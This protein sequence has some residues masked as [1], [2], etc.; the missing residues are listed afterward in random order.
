M[1]AFDWSPAESGIKWQ[2]FADGSR[3]T[4]PSNPDLPVDPYAEMYGPAGSMIGEMGMNFAK[5]AGAP[6][7]SH[8][9]E[10]T[11]QSVYKVNDWANNMFQ[12]PMGDNRVLERNLGEL[13]AQQD[14]LDKQ[15]ELELAKADEIKRIAAEQ[16]ATDAAAAETSTVFK[17]AVDMENISDAS[18][19]LSIPVE[20]NVLSERILAAGAPAVDLK[21][22]QQLPMATWFMPQD[23]K[24]KYYD[25]K[26]YKSW[27]N[28][29]TGSPWGF[30]A[31]F[32]PNGVVNYNLVEAFEKDPYGYW[33]TN[34]KGNMPSREE[35]V[36]IMKQQQGDTMGVRDLSQGGDN[37]L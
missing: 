33:E 22:L 15:A 1:A 23:T 25:M 36:E 2:G 20:L 17:G 29:R 28:D 30:K 27:F 13:H 8:I 24:A 3:H 4:N 16:A 31:H 12:Y 9:D 11:G 14:Y 6:Q 37:D 21:Y 35:K 5:N 26:D 32:A 18:R 10:R 19:I 34:I 7:F